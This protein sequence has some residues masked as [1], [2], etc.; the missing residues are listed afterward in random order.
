MTVISVISVISLSIFSSSPRYSGERGIDVFYMGYNSDSHAL[1]PSF[2][3][4]HPQPFSPEYRGEG[5]NN[6]IVSGQRTLQTRNLESD[7]IE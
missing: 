7:A 4:P 6:L 1:S 2:P 3:G 5:S